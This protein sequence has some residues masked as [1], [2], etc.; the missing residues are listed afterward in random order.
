MEAK[1]ALNSNHEGPRVARERELSHEGSPTPSSDLQQA[2]EITRLVYERI[3][4]EGGIF[5]TSTVVQGVYAIRVVSANPKADREHLKKAFEILVKTTEEIQ[6]LS[7][8]AY[9]T[10]GNKLTSRT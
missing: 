8:Q 2:N 4:A 7:E 10:S 1:A 5:L 3:N 6:G 9:V